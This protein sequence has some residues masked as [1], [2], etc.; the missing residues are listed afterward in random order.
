MMISSRTSNLR[1]A[2]LEHCSSK[3]KGTNGVSL[4][5]KIR[6]HRDDFTLVEFEEMLYQLRDEKYIICT[7]RTWWITEHARRNWQAA[8]G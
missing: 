5:N 4:W 8:K 2:I 3:T 6:Q 7:N 1:I